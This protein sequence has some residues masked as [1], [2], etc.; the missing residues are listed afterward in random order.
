MWSYR[1]TALKPKNGRQL[2]RALQVSAE[3][4]I[5]D[6]LLRVPAASR[7]GEIGRI[8]AGVAPKAVSVMIADIPHAFAWREVAGCGGE[9]AYGDR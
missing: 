6:F 1:L 8:G 5:A 4:H 9:I 7:V 2:R 3:G